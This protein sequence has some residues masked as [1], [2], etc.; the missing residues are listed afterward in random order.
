MYP[1]KFIDVISKPDNK[2]YEIC[3]FDIANVCEKMLFTRVKTIN[4]NILR[5]LNDIM[6]EH[7]ID[8]MGVI[9]ESKVLTLVNSYKALEVIK[10]ADLFEVFQDERGYHIRPTFDIMGIS[11]ET[12]KILTG[13]GL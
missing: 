6:I 8:F 11:E 12:Y 1:I 2:S 3:Q 13:A 4:E 9:D 5:Q 7:K 10:H